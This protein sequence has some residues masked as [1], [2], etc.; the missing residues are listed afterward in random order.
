LLLLI[1]F[2]GLSVCSYLTRKFGV[3]LASKSELRLHYFILLITLALALAQP[4]MP[5]SDLFPPPA[6]VWAGPA[7][8]SVVSD[9][10]LSQKGYLTVPTPL[11]AS[12]VEADQVAFLG[13]LFLFTVI[14]FGS[15]FI[16]Y[17]LRSLIRT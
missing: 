12:T 10:A 4:M 13:A 7:T 1:G 17:D 2:T 8:T 16:L 14:I 5:K 15:L 6:K 3:A 9:Y 11:G